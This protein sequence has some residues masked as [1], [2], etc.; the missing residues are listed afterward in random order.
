M[1]EVS[2]GDDLIADRASGAPAILVADSDSD[3]EHSSLLQVVARPAAASTNAP[4]DTAATDVGTTKSRTA[5]IK[6]FWPLGAHS[7]SK[8]SWRCGHWRNAERSSRCCCR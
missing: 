8:C 4:F 3:A 7:L 1:Q 6:G 2:S 5:L